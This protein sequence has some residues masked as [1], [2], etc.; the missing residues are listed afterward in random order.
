VVGVN[1]V[2]GVLSGAGSSKVVE[3]IQATPVIPPATSPEE[4]GYVIKNGCLLSLREYTEIGDFLAPFATNF[5]IY[6]GNNE[7]TDGYVCTGYILKDDK[8]NSYTI[9]VKGDVDGSGIIDFFDCLYTKAIY[10]NNYLPNYA[11]RYAAVVDG[12]D[13]VTLFDYLQIKSH[14]FER[15]NLYE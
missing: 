2:M 10:Y 12:G 5:K 3:I 15:T 6:S 13:E 4:L 14:Y 9:V 11:E 7:I 8:G 1:N